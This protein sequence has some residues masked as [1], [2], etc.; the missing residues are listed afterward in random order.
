MSDDD[1]KRAVEQAL[2]EN[3]AIDPTDIIV[4]VKDGVV[5]LDGF[6]R[7]YNQK[8]EAEDVVKK[9]PDVVSVANDIEVRL[10]LIH[11][12]PDPDIARDC[13]EWIRY[14]VP[15]AADRIKVIVSGGEVTLEGEVDS[16]YQRSEAEAA[17]RKVR[18]VKAIYNMIKVRQPAPAETASH[19]R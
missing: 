14:R 18:G 2:R 15:A 5:T 6:V 3:Q 1:I 11:Q 12:R 9:L 7:G 10:P 16:D 17:V 19:E 13:L 4:S 8:W